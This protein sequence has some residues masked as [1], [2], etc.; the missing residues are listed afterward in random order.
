MEILVNAGGT[1]GEEQSTIAQMQFGGI[2]FAR[3][4]LRS[5]AQFIQELNVLQMPYLYT[6]ADHM[7]EVLEGPVGDLFFHTLEDPGLVALSWYDAGARD[8]YSASKP[9]ETLED[10]EGMR[11]RV[12]DSDLMK[13]MV[14]AMGA[15][16]VPM[17]HSQ[18][19]SALET[20][21]IDA[22]EN[23]WPS[24]DPM[25]HYEAAPYYTID[26][27]TRVPEMQIMA[28]ATWER[29]PAEQQA[30]I[31]ECARESA[32]YERK[33][34]EERSRQ[35]E[36]RMRQAGCQIIELSPE[37]KARFREAMMPVCDEYCSGYMDI[38]QEIT[39]ADSGRAP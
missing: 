19:Y 6:G 11:I 14:E 22:A 2:D 29:L 20:G 36:E 24:Y 8:F 10:V 15:S 17:D 4:S 1:L 25:R 26:E 13:A 35:S 27:H 37:E 12:Q 33:L 30:V 28:E 5:L 7:W 18:V 32:V 31:L 23:N 21:L 16:A 3:V 34:W 9:I 38:I 39:E